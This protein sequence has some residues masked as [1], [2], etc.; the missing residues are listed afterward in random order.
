MKLVVAS[1]NNGKVTQYMRLLESFEV[2]V[3]SLLE[4]PEIEPIPEEDATTVGNAVHKALLVAGRTGLLAIADD[5]ILSLEALHGLPNIRTAR[6]AGAHA[7]DADNRQLLLEGLRGTSPEQRRASFHIAL[8]V[9]TPSEL[10][11][12][13]TASC[14][15][16][17]ST[18]ER[19]A[20]GFG[21]DSIF[22]PAGHTKTLAELPAEV[23]LQVSHRGRAFRAAEPTIRRLALGQSSRT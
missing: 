12:V 20:G 7:T 19:G 15:G 5:T 6:F 3:V 23:A 10:V 1:R 13:W 17:I 4:L 16:S 8:A 22:I 14:E 11:G 2:D 21:Y 18:H 9:A